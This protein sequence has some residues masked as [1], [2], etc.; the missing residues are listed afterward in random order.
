[1][2]IDLKKLKKLLDTN[3]ITP[4]EYFCIDNE[5]A[6]IK[7]FFNK[8]G[9]FLLIYIPSKYR[10]IIKSENSN[11]KIYH[12]EDID[13]TT[14]N[15]DYS[16]TTV[17]PDMSSIEPDKTINSYKELS[18]KY[19]K[20]I[21]LEGHDEPVTRKI[22]RQIE[23]VK[24]P[25]SR[26]SYNIALQYNNCICVSFEDDISLFG[27]KAYNHPNQTKTRC[28]M[29]LVKLPELIEHVEKI[30]N[31]VTI[32]SQQFYNIIQKVSISNLD[33]VKADIDSYDTI[34]NI[35]TKKHDQ[36]LGSI[37][38]YQQLYDTTRIK[39]E[40]VLN[41]FRNKINKEQ[42]VAKATMESSFQKQYDILFKACNEIIEKG[43]ELSNRFQRNLLILEEISFDNVIMLTRVRKNFELFKEIL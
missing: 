6:L 28:F 14:E 30:C 36:Y 5:C 32:I 20:N 12:I 39:E 27:I 9:E 31:Q 1:M 7:C 17:M 35:V 21:S 26:L 24:L 29:F 16:K 33:T 3:H 34:L 2:S 40:K 42:G 19:E 13:E 18:K 38:E 43:V 37:K 11:D 25:F 4:L 41:E 10:F 15:D 8:N 22:K 23:R